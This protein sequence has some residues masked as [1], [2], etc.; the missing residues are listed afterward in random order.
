M[1]ADGG[2]S[3]LKSFA[4]VIQPFLPALLYID[5]KWLLRATRS[6]DARHQ[7]DGDKV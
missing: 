2:I 6:R 1:R 5:E 3:A 4:L 7:R